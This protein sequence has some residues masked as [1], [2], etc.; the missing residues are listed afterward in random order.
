MVSW[1]PVVR[2]LVSWGGLVDGFDQSVVVRFPVGWDP[3]LVWGAVGVLVDRH[4][5]LRLRVVGGRGFVGESGVVDVRWAVG[6]VGEEYAAARGRLSLVDGVVMQV[7][8]FSDRLLLVVHHLV[9]DGVSWRV[10]LGDLAEVWA[11]RELPVVGTSVWEWGARLEVVAG[12]RGAELSLWR[13]ILSGGD[14]L[15]GDRPLDPAVDTAS[16]LRRITV[17]V[18]PPPGNVD[19]AVRSAF[20]A[21]VARWR[22]ERGVAHDGTVLVDVEGHGREEH[23]VDGVDLSRTVG[24]FTT[25][26]PERLGVPTVVPDNGIGYGLLRYLNPETAA[27]LEQLPTPQILFNHHGRVDAGA[28]PLVVESFLGG[29]GPDT[30]ATHVLQVNSAVRD[31]VLV[32]TWSWAGLVLPEEDVRAL[33]DHWAEEV[34][35]ADAVEVLPLAPLQEG[36]LF[37]ALYDDRTPDVYTAQLVLELTGDVDAARLRVAAVR[38]VARHDNLRV[39]FRHEGRDRPVQLVAPT[40]EPPWTEVDLSDLTDDE[41]ARELDRLVAADRVERFDLGRPPL[42][43][44]TLVRLTGARHRLLVTHHHILLDGWSMPVMLGELL[45]LYAGVALP[46]LTPYREFLAWHATRDRDAAERAWRDDLAGLTEPT[47]VGAGR[48]AA[49]APQRLVLAADAALTANLTGLAREHGVTLGGL[50]QAAWAVVLSGHTGNDDV[51]FGTT[52]SG[53][54]PEIPGVESMVGLFINTVPVRV[55]VDP[56]ESLVDLGR[57]LRERQVRLMPHEHLGLPEIQRCAN[58]PALFDTVVVVENYPVTAPRGAAADLGLGITPIDGSDPTHY[59]LTLAVIPGDTLKLRLEYRPDVFD[60]RTARLFLDRLLAVLSDPTAPTGA[61]GSPSSAEHVLLADWGGVTRDVPAAT[62]PELFAEQVA[63]RPD[64]PAVTSAGTTLTYAEL[65]ARANRLAHLLVERGAGPDR[66]VAVALPRSVELVVA[67]LAVLK[68]GAAYVPVDPNYPAARIDFMLSDAR[69][70]LVIDADTAW[71]ERAVTR[72][73]TDPA[74]PLSTEHP[75]YVIYTSGSTGRPK[76]VVVTHRGVASLLLAQRDTVGAGPGSRVLQFASPSFDAAFWELCMS[77]LSGGC[78]VLAPSDRLLPGEPLVELLARERVT[79]ALIPPAALAALPDGGLPAGM[80]LM[81]GG[82]ACSAA[83]VDRFADDVRMINAYGPTESTVIATM[84]GRLTGGTPP[85]GRPIPNTRLRVLDRRLRPV[86]VG[87]AGELY[88]G[89]PG[90]ARGYLRRPGLTAQRFVADPFG[91]PGDVVYRT[92]DVVRWRPDGRLEFVGRADEQV[93]VRG[94]RIEP[95]EVAAVLADHPSVRRAEVVVREDTPGDRRLVAYLVPD[96]Q[97]DTGAIRDHCARHLAEHMVPSAFVV[98]DVMPLTPNGKLDRAALP[99]PDFTGLLSGAAPTTARERVLCDL[100]GEVLGVPDIG[101]HDSFFAL[102]GH[103]LLATRLVS[104]IRTVFDAELPIRALFEAPTVAE[105]ARRLGG[106]ELARPALVR[107]DRPARVPLSFAQRRLWFLNRFDRTSV[108]YNM[109]LAL[110]L[111][112]DL[113]DRALAEALADVVI[114][115]ESLRTVFPD[116]DGEPHQL[117]L[118]P[119]R[120]DLSVVPTAAAE[121]AEALRV[122]AAVP[123]DLAVDPPLRVRLFRLAPDDHVLLVVLHHIAGDGWSMGPL[124]RDLSLAYGARSRETAPDWPD[125]PVQY[126]DYTLWQRETLGEE[127][128]A[129]SPIGAQLAYWSER[130]ADLPD[131]IRLPADRPRPPVATSRGGSVAFAVDADLH[132]GLVDLATA[133]QVSLFMVVQVALAAL[134][135]GLGAGA[136]IPIGSPIAGR[137]DDALDELVG[138]FVN[139]LVLRTDTSGDPTGAQL[140]AQVRE[141]NLA[142]YANQDLPF[143]RLV[144]VLNPER[145]LARHPLFQVLLTF[146]NITEVRVD[147][148]GLVARPVQVSGEAIKLDLGFNFDDR[149]TPDGAPLGMAGYLE[150]SELFE[151]D[152]AERITARLVRVFEQLVADPDRPISRI[153][154]LA[155]DE[156][157]RLLHEWNDTARAVSGPTLPDLFQARA[158][159][160]PDHPA[161]ELGDEVLTYGEL[162]RRANRLARL[163]VERGAGPERFVAIALPRTVDMVVAVLATLKAGAAYLPVDPAYPAERVRHMLTDSG[164][165]VLL[166]ASG[167]SVPGA[168]RFDGAIVVEDDAEVREVVRRLPDHDLADSDR[169]S[170]LLPD[171]PAYVIYTSGSTGRPKGVVA[172]HGGATALS[173]DQRDRFAVDHDTRVLQFASP[174]FDAAVLETHVALTSGATLVLA[175]D[176]RRAPGAPLAALISD[177]RVN[178]VCLPPTVVAAFP[179]DAELPA[180]LRMLVAGEAFPP[181]LVDRVAGVALVVNGYGPSECSVATTMSAPLS[182]GGGAP[183]G[184]P[185]ANTRVYVLDDRLR[186]TPVGVVAELYVSGAGVARGYTGRPGLTAQRFVACPFE[187][188]ARMYRTGDLVRWRA[189][190]QLEFVG[191]VDHQVKV[192]GYRVELGE[193]DAVVGTCPG[194]SQ[195]VTVLRTDEAGAA[196]ACYVV[197]AEPGVDAARLREHCARSLPDYLVPSVFVLLDAFPVTPNGKLDRTALPAPTAVGTGLRGPRTPQQEVLCG[198]FADTLGLPRVGVDQ[199]FFELGGHSLLATRLMSRVRATFGVELPIRTLFE[200]PTAADLADRLGGGAGGDELDVLLPL[201]PR[202]DGRP[203]FCVHA[204]SGISWVYSGLMRS[205][206]PRYPLYGLQARGLTD[207]ERMPAS[208]DEMA[209]DYVDQ[210]RTVQPHGPY[211]LLGWSFGGGV[212]HAMAA[213]LRAAGEEV[214]FLG[215]LDAY[216]RNDEIGGGR[217]LDEQGF[218]RVMLRLAGLD[219]A[220]VP[221]GP[222]RHEQVIDLVRAEGSLLATLTPEHVRGIAAVFNNN[223]VIQKDFVP[224]LFDGDV[225]FFTATVDQVGEAH[226]WAPHVAG[227]LHVHGIACAHS[228]MTDPGPLAEIGAIVAAALD[229]KRWA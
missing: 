153:D 13:G 61:V 111:E 79:H 31:G 211:Q 107:R 47:L 67:V 131:E 143:E 191:R 128:D 34:A 43:R 42:I 12:E 69:P 137:T 155:P 151:P 22:T 76:G 222:L 94:F 197:A 223:S 207:R 50:V 106:A 179:P 113:D 8:V 3:G 127:S 193:V 161:V 176:E 117:V 65:N 154:L 224:G 89:G 71:S 122:A 93:K 208:I 217:E 29:P 204:G 203:L 212:A 119:V 133:H 200:A 225:H 87:M 190:G 144:E 27:V 168:D 20:A 196:L 48:P 83:L 121:L 184:A 2:W 126:A 172:T 1:L 35:R 14:P 95:G 141:S 166:R 147:L 140:L 115:H 59:P 192:R 114:R 91:A 159:T 221:A 135:T 56:A 23:I 75:A 38:L 216:P 73:D 104:R 169:T 74:P 209:A 198:L 215:L 201:R 205:L 167:V 30:P 54:P 90:L 228:E 53:R 25:I 41:R 28:G 57:G 199:S 81:V 18:P 19:V 149:R 163:L 49:V 80:T 175:S 26:H 110:R 86:P 40:A 186:P 70:L 24:W 112:G 105:V 16:T 145:S 77:L 102:G 148:A 120:P 37:H 4:E 88:L 171:H 160:A 51:V 66:L 116:V 123:F 32:S 46:P 165:A 118:D 100:F 226:E 218:Y 63:R 68:A 101:L 45:T 187:Q 125:L 210:V 138:V 177:A 152:T 181:E 52:V 150:H 6:G 170:P 139:T 214:S 78:L 96:G 82:E 15:L 85:I 72:P 10:L 5:V 58:A 146:Q 44:F 183:I 134:L 108:S 182:A 36:L 103:S 84:S 142:A 220:T 109:P 99:A 227:E 55:A 158:H 9:V 17:T 206:G 60:E 33:A 185:I 164:A 92:G 11:G 64:D 178:L 229:G 157:R 180:D 195:A 213:R 97:V 219:P 136:D 156:R 188:G 98:V 132:R 194:V 62:V 39:S 173:T 130:L 124:A 7:V 162:N 189:D 21:A 202:G 129:D 174:S